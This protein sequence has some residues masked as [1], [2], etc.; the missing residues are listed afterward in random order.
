M[1]GCSRTIFTRKDNL[2]RHYLKVHRLGLSEADPLACIDFPDYRDV[3]YMPPSTQFDVTATSQA[4][5]NSAPY[6]SDCFALPVHGIFD[7]SMS[8]V[9]QGF[10]G[11]ELTI[12]NHTQS[13]NFAPQTQSQ[14]SMQSLS[15]SLDEKGVLDLGQRRSPFLR[16]GRLFDLPLLLGDQEILAVPDTGAQ[17]NAISV[18]TLK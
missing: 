8:T 4:L 10:G 17:I 2:D 14:G 18:H 15:N 12:G 11:I 9:Y 13:K 7:G 1:P 16:E 6:S 5:S 3:A